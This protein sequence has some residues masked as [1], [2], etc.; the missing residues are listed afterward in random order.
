MSDDELFPVLRE[1]LWEWRKSGLPAR[2]SN[3]MAE[4]AGSLELFAAKLWKAG[5]DTGRDT[6]GRLERTWLEKARKAQLSDAYQRGLNDA[7]RGA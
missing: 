4:A 3:E 5:F 1:A 7:R 2:L 6:A